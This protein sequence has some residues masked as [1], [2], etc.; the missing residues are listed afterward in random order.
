MP[1]PVVMSDRPSCTEPLG[2]RA[3][4]RGDVVD[5]ALG[6]LVGVPVL[7]RRPA[8]RVDV[9]LAPER[10][11]LRRGGQEEVQQTGP[12]SGVGPN[13]SLSANTV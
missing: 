5:T 7:Q 12:G 6:R 2:G 11:E 3:D 4:V 8:H 10:D 1:R 9:G 13:V